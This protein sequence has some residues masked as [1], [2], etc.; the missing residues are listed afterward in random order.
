MS[1]NLKTE[2]SHLAFKNLKVAGLAAG[3]LVTLVFSGEEAGAQAGV[4]NGVIQNG[5]AQ[6]NARPRMRFTEPDPMDFSN[7]DGYISLLMG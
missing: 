3:I 1:N 2:M 7:H 6:T 4:T 5:M